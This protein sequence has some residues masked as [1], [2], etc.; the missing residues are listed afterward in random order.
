MLLWWLASAQAADSAVWTGTL[1]Q[2]QLHEPGSR[3]FRLWADLHA[4]RDGER[5]VG[6]VRPGVGFDLSRHTSVYAGYAWI[7]TAADEDGLA[8]EHRLWEQLIWTGSLAPV[9]L[10]VRPRL[11]QRFAGGAAGLRF[12][13]F[14][15][16]QVDLREPFALVLS[17]ETFF[18]LDDAFLPAGFDQ[19]RLFLGLALKGEGFRVEVGWLDQRL[20]R[21]GAWTSVEAVSTTL[22][23][24]F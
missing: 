14:L 19:N 1:V 24:N 13:L 16:G 22:F 7:G 10:T 9:G 6:I 17:D 11:E 15:R 18:G 3:G 5:L 12:R 20:W 4:R 8:H 23:V 2:S 21:E